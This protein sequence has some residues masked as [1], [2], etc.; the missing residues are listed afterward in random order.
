MMA[1]VIRRRYGRLKEDGRSMP[2]LILVDG[3]I[4]QL[5]A[6]RTELQRLGLEGIAV[7]ALAKRFEEIYTGTSK[8]PVLLATDSSAIK[9]LQ[10]LRDEA[11]RFALAYHQR[12]RAK[13]IRE[14]RL[15]DIHGLGAKRKAALLRHFGSVERLRQASV[16]EIAA[17]PG[18]GRVMAE[19]I[20]VHLRP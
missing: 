11:H 2:D 3:G 9:V 19:T 10:R 15:D 12:L 14:S 13:L 17:Q 6:A 20:A 16:E 7:A 8:A 18:V 5:H 4:P 1:E